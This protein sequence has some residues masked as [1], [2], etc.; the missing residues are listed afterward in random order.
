MVKNKL[1]V[2]KCS[3]CGN[4]IEVLHAGGGP[5]VCCGVDM[6]LLFEKNSDAGKEKHVPV[7]EQ[8]PNGYKVKVGS[9]PHPME[10]AHFIEWIELVASEK[11]YRVFLKPG[12]APEAEFCVDAGEVSARIYCNIHGLWRS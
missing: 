11:V 3:I 4:I 7:I 5:L 2:Y 12:D 1:E 6:E 9:V 8:T 10:A